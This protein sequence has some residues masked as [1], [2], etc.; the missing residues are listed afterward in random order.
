MSGAGH[1]SKRDRKEDAALAALLSCGTIG[2]AAKKA[3]I[4]E[5]TLKRW[6]QDPE[7]QARYREARQQ[8]MQ[9]ALA[10]LQQASTAAVATLARNLTCGKETVEVAAAKALLEQAV[11]SA[12]LDDV[13]ARIGELEQAIAAKGP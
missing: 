1:G 9:Q 11:K 10:A 4:G 13:M 6:L 12:E 5:A 2:E 7:F 8:V 3:G